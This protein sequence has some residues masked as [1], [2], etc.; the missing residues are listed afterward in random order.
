MSIQPSKEDPVRRDLQV[1]EVDLNLYFLVYW[2]VLEIGKGPALVLGSRGYEIAKFDCFGK[3]KGHY[4]LRPKYGVRIPFTAQNPQQQILETQSLLLD[5]GQD[6]IRMVR[7]PEINKIVIDP[8]KLQPRL[9]QVAT[10]M[11]EFLNSK[12][13]LAEL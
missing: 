2:K 13:E 3:D 9:E 7:D 5:R 8:T 12:A 11:L 6:F 4:H 10:I 1:L